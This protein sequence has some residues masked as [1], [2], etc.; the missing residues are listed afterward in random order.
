MAKKKG[1]SSLRLARAAVQTV[2]VLLA[3]Y[4]GWAHQNANGNPLD[5]VCPFGAVASLPTTIA[6]GGSYLPIIS[7]SNFILLGAL[8]IVTLLAGGIFCGWLCPFGAL[9]DAIYGIRKFFWKKTLVIPEKVDKYLRY[10][11]YALLILVLVMSATKLTLWFT[12]FDPYRAFFHFGIETE[13]AFIAIGFILIS[14]ILIE[15]FWCRYL[16]PLGAIVA[17]LSKLGLLKLKKNDKC[18]SCNL[19]MKKCSMGLKEINDVGC[20]NCMD[21]VTACNPDGISVYSG[22]KKT[23]YKHTGI[24]AT[25]IILAVVLVLGSMGAGVWTTDADFKNVALP[26]SSAEFKG[27]PPVGKVVF[28]TGYFDEFSQIYDFTASEIYA[29]L[30]L[31]PNMEPHQTVKEVT[32]KYNMTEDEVKDGITKMVQER[33]KVKK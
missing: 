17:P 18:T 28:C 11:K 10:L 21:C 14:T 25:G 31:D 1:I 30:G 23:N 32:T 6:T 8:I 20:N 22:K 24:A 27:Y 26:A 15:R 12:E 7:D 19:C 29:G 16:C 4:V 9:Q 13:F 2:M 33:D 3:G 5:T